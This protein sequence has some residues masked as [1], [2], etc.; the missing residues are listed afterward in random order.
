MKRLIP[1]KPVYSYILID[2]LL[3]VVGFYVVLDWFPLTTTNPFLKYSVPSLFYIVSWLVCSYLLQ[4]YK[5]FRDQEYSSAILKLFYTVLGV[6]LLYW[7]VLHFFFKVYSGFVL[8]TISAGGFI[9]NY[10][11]LSLVFA[12]KFAVEYNEVVFEPE[13]GR[14]QAHTHLSADIDEDSLQHILQTIRQH[15]G[16]KALTF[17]SE[18]IRLESGNTRVYVKTDPENLLMNRSYRYSAIV[19]LERMNNMREIN[20]TLAVLNQKLPDH[21]IFICCYESK[22]TRKSRLLRKYP[23]GLN[24]V[25][26]FLDFILKRIVP[27]VILLSELYYFI[28]KGKNRILSKTEML[29]RLYCMG[30]KVV[31][32][33]KIG[34]LTWV[35]AERAKQPEKIQ[36]RIYGPLIT[37][38]RFGKDKIPF[39]V[40]KMRTM[41]PYSEYLQA[42]IYERNSLQEGGKFKRDIRVTTLGGFMRKY[43]LDELPMFINLLKGDMK[44]VGVRPLSAHYFSLYSAELQQ[45]R[46]K[47]KPGLLPPFYADMP[48]T[49]DEIQASEMRYLTMCEEKTV[50]FTDLKYILRILHNILIKK[51][52]S[53]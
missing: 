31:Q 17:L 25:I 34:K 52:R 1:P 30:F 42:Y 15:S 47:F 14:T 40:Y 16:E 38:K 36:K 21:G 20:R 32:E 23:P 45:K 9:V 7:G 48:K 35:V 26:Y 51:A 44:I 22:S 39:K 10:L 3:L 27:K 29:G 24:H 50:F 13:E 11:Y 53:A 49:L 8:L 41:H 19:Q 4:R 5:P 28:T 33:K 12:Y 18:T 43:W 2:I 37:L 6:F 46:V